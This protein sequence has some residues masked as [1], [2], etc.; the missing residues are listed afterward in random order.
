MITEDRERFER[1][2]GCTERE[3]LNW[4]PGA[5]GG[6]ALPH[7]AAGTSNLLVP[8]D[9]GALQLSWQVLP[10]RVIALARIPRLAVSFV[11]EGVEPAARREFLRRFDLFLQRGGG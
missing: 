9:T 11:F 5:T 7:A 4:M 3:W 1:E 6:R 2:Y 10:P 8:L